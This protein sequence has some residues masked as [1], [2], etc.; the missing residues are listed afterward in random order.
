MLQTD[1]RT[2]DIPAIPQECPVLRSATRFASHTQWSNYSIIYEGALNMAS[3]SEP[4][5][6]FSEAPWRPP[7]S[8]ISGS[9]K[10]QHRCLEWLRCNYGLMGDF[11]GAFYRTLV[12]SQTRCFEGATTSFRGARP[13]RNSTTGDSHITWPL[14]QIPV[15]RTVGNQHS[16]IRLA[17]TDRSSTPDRSSCSPTPA[18]IA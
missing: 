4:R 5:K 14:I 6:F 7:R 18:S 9:K 11:M 13:P 3:D 12:S 2:D 16:S 10:H 1:R 15:D 17:R 8:H